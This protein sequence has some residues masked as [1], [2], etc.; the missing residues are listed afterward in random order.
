LIVALCDVFRYEL[1]VVGEV[2]KLISKLVE[3]IRSL[4][5]SPTYIRVSVNV[6]DEL[7]DI[8]RGIIVP[9]QAA[10]YVMLRMNSSYVTELLKEVIKLGVKNS[11]IALVACGLG[12]ELPEEVYLGDIYLRIKTTPLSYALTYARIA[13]KSGTLLD[14]EGIKFNICT[15]T[16]ELKLVG[17]LITSNTLALSNDLLNDI[18]HSLD[19]YMSKLGLNS[20]HISWILNPR[21]M[22]LLIIDY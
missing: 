8:F 10:Q 3:E 15:L 21:L 20:R 4:G 17:C 5:D 18:I 19:N 14:L 22:N 13:V 16:D 12:Y 2:S 6:L 11:Y 9:N 7:L 1:P